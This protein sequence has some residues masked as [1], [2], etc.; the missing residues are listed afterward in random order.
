[1]INNI[2]VKDIIRAAF[3]TLAICVIIIS[4]IYLER[5]CSRYVLLTYRYWPLYVVRIVF[6]L[7]W[8]VSARVFIAFKRKKSCKGKVRIMFPALGSVLVFIL[9]GVM[10]YVFLTKRLIGNQL[11]DIFFI[12]SILCVFMK[13]AG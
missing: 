12:L 8:A 3:I 6:C 5:L 1:M 7:V 13:E 11:F 10:D 4:Q 2:K 9:I